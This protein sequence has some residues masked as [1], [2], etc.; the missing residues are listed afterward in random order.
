[1]TDTSPEIQRMIRKKLMA[2][3]GE[4]RF[5]MGAQMCES[6]REM[7]NASLPPGLS[8]RERRRELFRRI[9]GK[10]TGI[11]KLIWA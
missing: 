6:A 11:E 1:M 5:I 9:Y 2:L 8:E 4:A 3:S 10:E 7:V